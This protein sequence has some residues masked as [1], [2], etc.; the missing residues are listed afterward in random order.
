MN[1][2]WVYNTQ[3]SYQNN[4]IASYA[5]RLSD[6]MSGGINDLIYLVA[7]AGLLEIANAASNKSMFMRLLRLDYEAT[8]AAQLAAAW[9]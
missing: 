5:L 9:P 6:S 2:E 7:V 3:P 4:I 1:V 8:F